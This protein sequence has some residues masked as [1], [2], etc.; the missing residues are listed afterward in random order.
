MKIENVELSKLKPNEN[1]PRK[2]LKAKL[3]ELKK[4]FASFSGYA[5]TS[6]AYCR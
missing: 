2:I 1:N 5:Q 3:E 6:P 4:I